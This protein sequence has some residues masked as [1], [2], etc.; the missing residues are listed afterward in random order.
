[1]NV[2][3]TPKN[4]AVERKIIVQQWYEQEFDGYGA[5]SSV[6]V[7]L[8]MEDA[9]KFGENYEM[10]VVRCADLYGRTGVYFAQAGSKTWED[11]HSEHA[12]KNKGVLF[13]DV[14][15]FDIGDIFRK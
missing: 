1:M 11:L 7:H 10:H 15:P 6:S 5:E 8:T 14:H 2:C 9:R 4:A 13:S 3:E 12:R